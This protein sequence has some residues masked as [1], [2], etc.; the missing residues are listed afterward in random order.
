[1]DK[2]I[3]LDNNNSAIQFLQQRDK[4]MAKV[5]SMVGSITYMPYEDSYSFLVSQIIGQMLSNKAASIIF[6]RLVELCDDQ[7]TPE[8]IMA[9]SDSEIKTIGTS[10][11]KVCYIRA[12]TRAVIQGQI[13]FSALSELPDQEVIRQLTSIRGIGQWSA[14]MYL[15]FVLNRLD[16]LPYED[17]AFLQAYSWAYKT[18]YL[19]K[20][21]IEKKCMKWKPYRSIASRYLYKALDAGLTKNEFHLYK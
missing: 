1:M 5:I 16:V 14:K 18:K 19:D 10:T 11:P 15:I 12:L 9:L 2:I 4:R 21:S 17:G 7:V 13:D 8:R 6:S 20:A 3:T